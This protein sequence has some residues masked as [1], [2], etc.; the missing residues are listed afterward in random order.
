MYP[1]ARSLLYC[2]NLSEISSTG[3]LFPELKRNT[4]ILLH[5]YE[6][7]SEK[8]QQPKCSTGI[9]VTAALKTVNN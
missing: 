8:V 6:D 2:F 4:V 1:F 7:F 5:V 3:L 9:K